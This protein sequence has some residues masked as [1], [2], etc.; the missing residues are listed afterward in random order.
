MEGHQSIV[1]GE[2]SA[3]E[4]LT[5]TIEETA[6]ALG[7]G[8]NLAYALARE[9]RLPVV[10]LGRRLLVSRTALEH[11]LRWSNRNELAAR[12]APPRA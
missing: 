1:K 9:D 10:R 6:R 5:L 3:T 2:T 12:D 11:M 8:R 7:I 4:P